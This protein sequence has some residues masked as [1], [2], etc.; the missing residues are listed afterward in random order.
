MGNKEFRR[1]GRAAPCRARAGVVHRVGSPGR[2]RRMRATESK[3]KAAENRTNRMRNAPTGSVSGCRGV[4]EDEDDFSGG[5]RQ[6]LAECERQPAQG[7]YCA[8]EKA[9]D[10][11]SVTAIVFVSGT[12]TRVFLPVID[13]TQMTKVGLGR[14]C[15]CEQITLIG[16]FG[17]SGGDLTSATARSSRRGQR[18]FLFPQLP[19]TTSIDYPGSIIYTVRRQ[20][21]V[22]ST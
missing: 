16:G 1:A 11:S 4:A 3:T 12:T 14:T 2:R 20:T 15:G 21:Q 6:I 18:Y 9:L 7:W 13:R 17:E 5:V 22:L 8:A 10:R 19:A